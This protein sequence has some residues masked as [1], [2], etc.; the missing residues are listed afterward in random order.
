MSYQQLTLDERYQIQALYLQKVTLA[1]IGRLLGR[2]RST[3]S[4]ELRRNWEPSMR[5]YQAKRAHRKA[6]ER[7]IAKGANQRLIQGELRAL[8]EHGLRRSWSPE[9]ITGRL[10]LEHGIQLS[11]ETIYQHVLR[12]AYE[13]KGS[14]RYCLRFGGYKH[15]RFRRSKHAERT[16]ARKRHVEQR[17]AAANERRELGHWERDC[18]VGT[19]GSA[20]LLTIVDRKSRYSRIRLAR[21]LDSDHVAEATVDALKSLAAVTKTI[22]NDNGLEFQRDETIQKRL[23]VPVYFCDPHSPWQ[24]GSIENLN[25]LIRQYVPKGTNIGLLHDALPAALQETLN[26][27]PRKVLGYR[28]PHE[29]FW[30]TRMEF[31]TKDT[32]HFGLEFARRS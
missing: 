31:M 11:H 8:V 17:P 2:H 6:R 28:T 19:K 25:G 4:R 29:V 22:T 15:R 30:N 20:V 21:K 27:R 9:Q 24:R 7:R 18:V 12:D 32:M 13:H 1:E 26:F 5:P 10:R 23:G 16:R 3:V 14:L